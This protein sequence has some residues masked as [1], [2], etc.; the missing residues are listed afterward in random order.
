MKNVNRFLGIFTLSLA[1]ALGAAAQTSLA[2]LD[3]GRV[4]VQAHNGKVVL[5]SVGA[6]WLPLSAKQAEYTNALAKKYAGKDVVV[7]F[8]STDSAKA[9]RNFKSDEELRAFAAS[10]R[11]TVPVLRDPEGAISSRKFS[12]EQVPSFVLLDK[13]G[14]VSGEVFGGIDPKYDV[15]VAIAKA[16][17]KLL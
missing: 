13:N 17:D 1:A 11:L 4:D 8:V 9:G 5:L 15:S 10:N 7:Y 16:I 3:G 6:A 2:T 12:V 14:N